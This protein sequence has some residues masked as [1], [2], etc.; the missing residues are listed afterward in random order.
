MLCVL[1]STPTVC[2]PVLRSKSRQ[3]RSACFCNQPVIYYCL[4]PILNE[5]LRKSQKKNY[6]SNISPDYL[7]IA[8]GRASIGNPR[9]FLCPDWCLH[10]AVFLLS[11]SLFLIL[12]YLTSFFCFLYSFRPYHLLAHGRVMC[13][14]SL[15]PVVIISVAIFSK[16][17]YNE[18]D[19]VRGSGDQVSLATSYKT[20]AG[21]YPTV[22]WRSSR[23]CE[24][25]YITN[26]AGVKPNRTEFC[27]TLTA[28]GHIHPRS[29]S[30][31]LS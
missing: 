6:V 7:R 18:G 14:L 27:R 15:C 25:D 19:S 23:E 4:L 8:A 3:L 1:C 5:P 13:V 22:V 2:R 29:G 16:I 28:L 17:N 21:F 9:D 12:L 31:D 11:P 20:A 24:P 30:H 10:H 26:F